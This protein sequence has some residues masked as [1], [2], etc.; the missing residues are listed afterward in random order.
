MKRTSLNSHPCSIARTLDVAGEWWAPLI[1]KDVAYGVRRFK[2]LQDDLG[3]LGQR[4]GRPPRG[5]GFGRAARDAPSTR[6]VLARHEYHL[7]EMG[8]DLIPALLAL[9]ELGAIAGAGRGDAARF[10]SCTELC[11]HEVNVEVR[12]P[13][14]DRELKLAELRAS[15]RARAGAKGMPGIPA[16]GQ[17]GFVSAGRLASSPDGRPAQRAQPASRSRASSAARGTRG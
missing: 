17:P 12:C 14:C 13:D 7:T 16:E 10:A 2:D 8:A 15:L 4:A 5:A 6:S 9:M 11:G 1:L 3:D